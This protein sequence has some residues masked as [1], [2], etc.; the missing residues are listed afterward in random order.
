MSSAERLQMRGQI[1]QQ[2]LIAYALHEEVHI[3]D[4]CDSAQRGA[5][6]CPKRLPELSGGS[7]GNVWTIDDLRAPCL[8]IAFQHPNA[9]WKVPIQHERRMRRVN[10]LVSGREP[11]QQ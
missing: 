3:V 5:D 4:R 8:G 9:L 10:Q 2:D 6:A 11:V 7:A 1:R